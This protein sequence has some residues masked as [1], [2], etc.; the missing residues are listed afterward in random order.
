MLDLRCELDAANAKLD[1]LS[2]SKS[3]VSVRDGM[4][5]YLR[6]TVNAQETKELSGK[7]CEPKLENV[8]AKGCV[9]CL[10]PNLSIL[11][12]SPLAKLLMSLHNPVSP[13]AKHGPHEPLNKPKGH[14][15]HT[16]DDATQVMHHQLLLNLLLETHRTLLTSMA[17][18]RSKTTSQPH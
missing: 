12:H 10:I 2:K 9:L 15:G 16:Q 5:E 11:V 14:Y 13:L 17:F 1:V 7:E 3:H 18:Y 8:H 4:N 6:K